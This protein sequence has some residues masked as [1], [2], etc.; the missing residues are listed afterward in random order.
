M[1][2]SVTLIG[3]LGK[4]PEMKTLANDNTLARILLAT[5]EYRKN[6]TGERIEDVNWHQV[7]AFGNVARI[8]EKYC[9][10]GQEIGISGK[11]VTRSYETPEGEKKYITEVVANEILLMGKKSA[12][13]KEV[14]ASK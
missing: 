2:N 1:N 13:E 11:L 3:R 10:K 4:D 6:A 7:V 9:V 8:V 5:N 14:E 12:T